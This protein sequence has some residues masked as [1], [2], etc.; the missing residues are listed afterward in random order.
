MCDNVAQSEGGGV[1]AT[2]GGNSQATLVL[3]EV[4]VCRNEAADGAGLHISHA[5]LALHV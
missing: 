5:P 2:S 4:T 1:L 3:R